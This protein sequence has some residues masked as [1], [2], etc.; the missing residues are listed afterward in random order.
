MFCGSAPRLSIFP[1]AKPRETST[2]EGPQNILLS[3]VSVNKYS[4]IY[5]ESKKRKNK[6]NFIRKYMKYFINFL[7]NVKFNSVHNVI[8]KT[9]AGFGCPK[10]A[11]SRDGA[12]DSFLFTTE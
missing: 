8:H 2:I 1:E 6:A 4:I 5:Q 7:K 11:C 3:R 10:S 9:F 12:R